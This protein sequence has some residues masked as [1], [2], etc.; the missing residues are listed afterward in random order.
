MGRKISVAQGVFL[1][2][3]LAN[4]YIDLPVNHNSLGPL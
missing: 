3:I 1:E 2:D 4:T